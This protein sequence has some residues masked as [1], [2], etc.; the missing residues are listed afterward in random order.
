MN[1]GR[2]S[3]VTRSDSNTEPTC[4]HSWSVELYSDLIHLFHL[5]AV[6]DA[7]PGQGLCALAAL[8]AGVPYLGICLTNKHR[9]LLQQQVMKLAFLEM[10]REGSPIYDAMLAKAL[11]PVGPPPTKKPRKGPSKPKALPKKKSKKDSNDEEPEE[12]SDQ[13]GDAEES[14]VGES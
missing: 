13:A 14:D 10:R 6:V 7:T 12:E 1:P 11:H 4:F 5:K 9:D 2:G 8:Q 3:T